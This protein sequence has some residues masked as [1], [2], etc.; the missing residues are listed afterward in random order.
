MEKKLYVR[1]NSNLSS[2]Q[3]VVWCVLESGQNLKCDTGMLL[4]TGEFFSINGSTKWGGTSFFPTVWLLK[5]LT[6]FHC[7]SV[8][9]QAVLGSRWQYVC[10]L[11][12][13]PIAT[14]V[15][16]FSCLLKC[17]RSLYGKQCGPRSDCSYRSSLFWVHAVCFYTRF[18]SNIRQ[19]FAADGFSRRHFQM[20]FFLVALRVKCL[21]CLCH[22]VLGVWIH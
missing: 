6:I 3:S 13:K 16:C 14:K 12:V 15:V 1:R 7:A 20:H 22:S 18:V 8:I 5:I 11:T 17:L 10:E 19:L 9:K 4:S 2:K 21:F